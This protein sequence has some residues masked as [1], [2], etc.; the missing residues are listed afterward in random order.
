[1]DTVLK[2]DDLRSGLRRA[3][4]RVAQVG[5]SPGVRV[6]PMKDGYLLQSLPS[7]KSD[8]NS[9]SGYRRKGPARLGVMGHLGLKLDN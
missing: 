7:V 6:V 1:M 4:D 5:P 2:D 9:P 8:A 3:L